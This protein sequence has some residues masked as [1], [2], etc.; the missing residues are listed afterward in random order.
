[1][2]AIAYFILQN[3]IV[4]SHKDN[5]DL[6]KSIGKN[7]KTTFSLVLYILGM[8][9][10]FYSPIIGIISYITVLIIWFIPNKKIEQNLTN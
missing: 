10:S 5:T 6:Q 4:K 2:S 7:S 8:I 1:M 3:S 9:I